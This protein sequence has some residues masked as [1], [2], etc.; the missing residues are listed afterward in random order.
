MKEKKV[1][2]VLLRA[3]VQG[4]LEALRHSL[5][6]IKSDK[7]EL[8]IVSEEVGQIS[9]SDI[10]LAGASGA[11]ILG[12]HTKVESHAESLIKEKKVT[13]KLHNIIYHAVD[14]MKEIMRSMLDKIEQE[15]EM[16]EAEVKAVFKSSHLGRIA[17]CQVTEGIIKRNHHARLKRK[18]ELLWKGNIASLKRVKEDVREVSKGLECGILLQGFHDFQEGDV[19]EAYE[20]SYLEQEL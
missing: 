11:M 13:V 10:E 14:E 8:N 5:E 3:D 2:H 12:F 6:K 9:E 19:I 15:N 20:I 7:A 18:G 4:S 1:L 16:G 17:G